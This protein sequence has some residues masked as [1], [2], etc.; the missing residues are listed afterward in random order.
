MKLKKK[1]TNKEIQDLAVDFVENNNAESFLLSFEALTPTLRTF[2]Y[3]TLV[4]F[5]AV[6]PGVLADEV[7]HET[8]CMAYDNAL[9]GYYKKEKGK[10]ITWVW[11][12]A[13]R[14]CMNA[15]KGE[16]YGGQYIVNANVDDIENGAKDDN[17]D[18]LRYHVSKVENEETYSYTING[19]IREVDMGE[20]LLDIHKCLIS[21]IF[22]LEDSENR[23]TRAILKY[24]YME[25]KTFQE[26]ADYLDIPVYTVRNCVT[27]MK[28][29]L[30][31]IFKDKYPELYDVIVKERIFK[32]K[33]T[34]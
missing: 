3:N 7:L 27:A 34:A 12:I 11:S 18:V 31:D 21:C 24:L 13:R 5:N 19:E 32:I 2:I 1:L 23:P 6:R 20:L 15:V 33:K 28:K 16:M 10:F 17:G 26:I 8:E 14:N 25:N 29:K 22:Y 30:L 4:S 9:L